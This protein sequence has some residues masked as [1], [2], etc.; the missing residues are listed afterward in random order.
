MFMRAFKALSNLPFQSLSHS[1]HEKPQLPPRLL[2]KPHG[3]ACSG[4]VTWN[5]FFSLMALNL[6]NFSKVQ[7]S[8]P[9]VILSPSGS[10]LFVYIMG[11]I[12]HAITL[13][14]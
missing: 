14:D 7:P 2:G 3:W 9:L 8:I 11:C 4:P 12:V 5:T 13:A 6:N 1:F 10:T